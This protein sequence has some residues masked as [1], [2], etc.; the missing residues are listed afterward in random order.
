M[1]RRINLINMSDYWRE[2]FINTHRRRAT[3]V[4]DTRD[5]RERRAARRVT[6]ANGTRM[7]RDDV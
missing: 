4:I 3:H 2:Q 5:T 7:A 6:H 1:T